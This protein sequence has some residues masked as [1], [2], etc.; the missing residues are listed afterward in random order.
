MTFRPREV[1]GP[2]ME[3]M[4]GPTLTPRDQ[5]FNYT[6]TNF[7]PH[8]RGYHAEIFQLMITYNLP[9]DLSCNKIMRTIIPTLYAG[10][11][12]SVH[13][14]VTENRPVDPGSIQGSHRPMSFMRTRT[15]ANDLP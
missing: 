12:V 3:V 8:S 4:A 7:Q 15:R 11:I 6:E 9:A 5:T 1:V 2:P 13:R 10:Y 14:M